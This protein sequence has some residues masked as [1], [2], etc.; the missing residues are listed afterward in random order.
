MQNISQTN[1]DKKILAG[2]RKILH[3]KK[4]H[5][6]LVVVSV[7]VTFSKNQPGVNPLLSCPILIFVNSPKSTLSIPNSST[8]FLCNAYFYY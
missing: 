1:S 2:K 7:I 8:P 6:W 4:N 3:T 5:C